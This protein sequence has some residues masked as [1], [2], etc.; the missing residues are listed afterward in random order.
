M[1]RYNF[2][3]PVDRHGTGSIKFDNAEA[4]HRSPDLLSLW[5]ADMDFRVPDEV[6]EALVERSRH[7]IFGYTEPD[8]AYFDAVETWL[9]THY[10][11]DADDDD[12]VTTPGVVYALAACVRAFTDPGDAVLI[13]PPVYYPFFS[14]VTDNGRRLVEAPLSYEDGSYRI[15]F[16]AFESLLRVERPNLFLL[17]SPHN[18]VGRV[19]TPDELARLLELCTA[20]D[21]LIVSDEIHADFVRPGITQTSLASLRSDGQTEVITCTSA[22]KTFNLAGLQVANIVIPNE[23]LRYRFRD[24]MF[25]SGYSQVNTLGLEATRAAYTYGEPWLEQ[26]LSYLEGNWQLLEECLDEADGLFSL[27]RAEGTYLAWIDCRNLGLDPHALERFVEDEA[28]LWLDCGHMFGKPGEGFIR[29]NIA[30][31]RA[32]LQRAVTQLIEAAKRR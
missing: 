11:I 29:I 26:L 22:S 23:R 30:T 8:R 32:Y 15:D 21:T 2:D 6:I 28:G 31:Q 10:A 25:S 24:A 16:D 12:I 27:I 17:C 4:R 13:Q 7:G 1:K 19:W 14:V 3:A 5:V 9:K 20:Y 18:P